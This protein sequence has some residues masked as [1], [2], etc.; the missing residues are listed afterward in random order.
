MMSITAKQWTSLEWWLRRIPGA[1][2]KWG[3]PPVIIHENMGV[4]PIINHPTIGVFLWFSYC[5]GY[6]QLQSGENTP[7]LGP[8]HPHPL[9]LPKVESF[10]ESVLAEK[11]WTP[12]GIHHLSWVNQH[13]STNSILWWSALMDNPHLRWKAITFHGKSASSME[14]HWKIPNLKWKITK[15][16]GKIHMFNGKSLENHHFKWRITGKF[17]I[18]NG[19]C[20][21]WINYCYFMVMNDFE[22]ESTISL[23]DESTISMVI[24]YS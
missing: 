23:M 19:K 20:N 22:G 13:E 12:L 5:L 2:R 3:C 9:P 18:F 15:N 24:N 7:I 16:H 21:G 17:T 8:P 11:G 1:F 14:N 10:L 6:P 4:F